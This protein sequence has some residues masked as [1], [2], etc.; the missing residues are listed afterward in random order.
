[1]TLAVGDRIGDWI[2]E[3][4]VGEGGM[5]AVFR[6]HST[7]SSEMK[8][9]LKVLKP[10]DVGQAKER[11]AQELQALARLTHPGIVRVLGGGEDTN[12]SLLYLVMEL[13]EGE[14]VEKRLERGPLP[15]D[16]AV[17]L[18]RVIAESLAFAHSK[19]I[20]HRDIKPANIML[21][22][23]AGPRVIDFGIAKERGSQQLTQAGTIAGTMAFLAPEVF[24]DDAPDPGRSDVYSLGLT[25][26]EALT[27]DAAY[28]RGGT[29]TGAEMG[30]L[31]SKK[32][33]SKAQDP[34]AAFPYDLREVVKKATAP[35]PA[36]RYDGMGALADALSGLKHA[37]VAQA[38]VHAKP[39]STV[40]VQIPKSAKPEPAPVPVKQPPPKPDPVVAA[41]PPVVDRPASG[42]M[43]KAGL[44]AGIG[45][46]G[47]L[48]LGGGAIALGGI[49]W[50][51]QDA[52]TPVAQDLEIT[53]AIPP[54]AVVLLDGSP[55]GERT[56]SGWKWTGLAEGPHAL[57]IAAGPGALGWTGGACPPC[58]PCITREITLPSTTPVALKLPEATVAPRDVHAAVTLPKATFTLDGKAPDAVTDAGATWKAVA[59]GD[60]QI[61]AATDT[62]TPAAEGCSARG[63]C[64][65]GCASIQWPAQVVCGEGVV[66]VAV[67]LPAPGAPPVVVPV[68]VPTAAPA[69][70]RPVPVPAPAPEP[71]AAPAPEP[72]PEPAAAS[73]RTVKIIA[74]NAGT[75]VLVRDATGTVQT[76]NTG[77]SVTVV[78]GDVVVQH[79]YQ[80]V[81]VTVTVGPA[82]NRITCAAVDSCAAK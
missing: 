66:E 62:C 12:R 68:P 55:T 20:F 13:L 77:G 57:A 75:G 31:I 73:T 80:G 21:V 22:P 48:I 37:S 45:L 27:G 81:P 33:S 71:V 70:A 58:T 11:F 53:A 40:A 76:V 39:P 5:G 78:T 65:P 14:S 7:L 60:H 61:L 6:V 30:R 28:G 15:A 18:F 23:G 54:D 72:E 63:D 3:G 32:L 44:L 29:T 1:M 19:G 38:N 51:S 52:G 10:H 47:A 42:G 34:G 9:A 36:D 46:F 41:P 26:Y 43:A 16:E 2:V 56:A 49:W 8:A 24:R 69:V 82:T 25:L 74:P 64:P 59:A 67:N 4:S 79:G 17:P 50:M 35:E